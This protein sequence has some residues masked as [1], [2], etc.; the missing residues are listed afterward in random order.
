MMHLDVL[1]LHTCASFTL[2]AL[3]LF[4][5]DLLIIRGLLRCT[6]LLRSSSRL[7]KHPAES[8]VESIYCARNP[9]PSGRA[10]LY[11]REHI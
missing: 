2:H 3:T 4:L 10:S 1:A 6:A 7:C 9:T 11:R 8:F 5:E